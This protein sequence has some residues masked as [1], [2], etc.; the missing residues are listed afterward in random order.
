M[1]PKSSNSKKAQN[2]WFLCE[3]CET[4]IILKDRNG[5]EKIC[6]ELSC[7]KESDTVIKNDFIRKHMLHTSTISKQD[8]SIEELK[9]VSEKQLN[10]LVFIS[11]GAMKLCKFIIGQD[12]C[13]SSRARETTS[14]VNLVRKVW[15]I[16]DKFLA[17]VF[18]NTQDFK[19]YSQTLKR[20][21]VKALSS[22]PKPVKEVKVHLVE[23]SG[24]EL[25]DISTKLSK[26]LQVEFRGRVFCRNTRIYFDFFNKNIEM[27]MENFQTYLEDEDE[28]SDQME[29]L[30]LDDKFYLMTTN[31]RI[32]IGNKL[33]VDTKKVEDNRVTLKDVGGLEKQI[34]EILELFEIAVGLRRV[35]KG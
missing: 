35:P 10:N 31:A 17:T 23:T 34:Q 7:D 26:V 24:L 8:S 19:N 21:T 11:E 27:V 18:F 14:A 5:H 33:Q 12:I 15:P 6:D 29:N 2:C 1:P 22:P 30:S 25:S 4:N 20:I 28:L 9:D 3:K 32:V 13:I 16:P